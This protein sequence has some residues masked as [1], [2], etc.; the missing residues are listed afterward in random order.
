VATIEP[1]DILYRR[2]PPSA[3][4]G[5]RVTRAAFMTNGRYDRE[6]SV[7]LAKLL[8][9]PQDCLRDR[10]RFGVGAIAVADVIRLGFTVVPDPLP[11]DPA[12]ALVIGE[13]DKQIA[14]ALART[15]TIVISP[16][17]EER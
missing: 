9:S 7:Q 11:G 13:N 5:D 14:R 12:H 8:G 2:L 10:P 17:I 16:S 1:D 15:M 6:L 4:D 3:V